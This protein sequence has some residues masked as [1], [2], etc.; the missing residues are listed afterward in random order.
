MRLLYL[1]CSAGIAGDMLLAAL[2]DLGASFTYV[3][4]G[5]HSLKLPEA[6]ELELVPTQR[7]GIS[8]KRLIVTVEGQVTD[9][10]LNEHDHIHQVHHHPHGHGHDQTRP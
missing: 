2:L 3:K 10:S 6:W 1:D 5:L 9:Q 8:A 4:E 7:R